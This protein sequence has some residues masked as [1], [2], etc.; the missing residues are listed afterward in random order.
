M[1]SFV[2]TVN[3]GKFTADNAGGF[4]IAFCTHEGKRVVV[5][6]DRYHQKR[7]NAQN[8]YW[9]AVPVA[10]ISEKTGYTPEQSH[11]AIVN[12]LHYEIAN[13]KDGMALKIPLT[14]RNLTTV[15]FMDLID[16]VQKWAVEFF[17]GLYIPSPN[18]SGYE[19]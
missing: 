13:G 9:W 2:G 8:K 14:T 5:T 7:S 16:K 17:D 10:L 3:K 11:A 19:I 12:E 18:E 4:D 1:T 15:Q 6:V